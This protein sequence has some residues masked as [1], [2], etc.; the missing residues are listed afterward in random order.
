MQSTVSPKKTEQWTVSAS[1]K[2]TVDPLLDSLVLLTEYFGNPCSSESL[3]A[4]LPLSGNILTPE[5]LPQAAGR[6]GL[7]AKLIHKGLNHVSAIFLPCI[8][9]LKDKKACLLREINFEEDYAIIQLP[10]TGGE[11]QLSIEELEAIYVGYLFMV[12]QQ[13]RGD[14]GPDLHLHDTQTHWLLQTLKDSAPIYRDAL[15]A[16]VLVNMFA[17][18]SPLFIMNVYDKVVPNLAFESLWVLAIGAGIAYTFDLVMR[19]LRAYLIDVAGK[20]VDIIVSSKLFAK[21]IGIPLEKRSPSIGGMARQLGE[22]DNI[23]DILTSATITTLVDLPFALFFLIIIYIVAGDLALIP[24]V[25]G[26]IILI[27]T[28]V[29]QPRLKSA[30]EESNKFSSAKH[31]HLVESLAAL[32]SIKSSGAEG[33]VQKSWQ[34]MIGHTANWQLKTKKISTSVTNMA[35]FAVQLSVIS[36]V[37]LGVYRVAD[38]AISMGGI[39]A[40]V[41]LSSRAIAPMAQ[42][43][44]LMTRGNYTASALRQ[45]DQVMTQEG[46]FDNKG[47]LVS[48]QRLRGQINADHVSF[49]YPGSE[50][51]VLNPMS[52]SIE[53]GERVA[54]IGRNGSGKS[55]LA[56]LLVGLYQPSKGSL[57]YDGLD[58]AQIHPTDLRR[59]FGYLPQDI[60][61]FHGTIRDNILF[62]TK[63]VTEH[64][65][66]RAVQLSGVNQFTDIETEGLDQQVG[67]GGQSLSR[68]QRQTIALARATLNDPPV[69]LMDE[70]TASLDARAE[71]QFIRAMKNAT[72]ERTLLLITHKMHL[73]TLVD[74]IIVL[75]RGHLIADGPKDTILN[76]LAKGMLSGGPKNE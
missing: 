56:K 26:I 57:R 64:Q 43:A 28:L 9:L 27:Y 36:V 71:K 46:E 40:A 58:S 59:N 73:L 12:K 37:I 23:R 38:N 42:L 68:G 70:P 20:K 69:L 10:E 47:H 6:A 19:Q 32:E 17:L 1:Q 65:L 35:N 72:K 8:L 76:Q 2:V 14:M 54:I 67:E 7:A 49:N 52:F 75:D 4:G 16:S 25:G 41:I 21:A 74:R 22:F 18:V 5:L 53:P 66:I 55:T 48:R 51:A 60:V 62:G 31:G 63:Q 33:L 24:L 3:A 39:I 44:G 11:Q 45:L 34:Q 29:M 15:I 13:Y 50:R 30:I 61:L